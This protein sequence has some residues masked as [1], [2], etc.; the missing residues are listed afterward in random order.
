MDQ[1]KSLGNEQE[2]IQ[3]Q[4]NEANEQ[5]NFHELNQLQNEL[6]LINDHQMK[7]V[8]EK[9]QLEQ[10]QPKQQDHQK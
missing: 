4:I 1:L 7:L 5:E 10:Q 2:Q 9:S 3:N 8:N 6:N